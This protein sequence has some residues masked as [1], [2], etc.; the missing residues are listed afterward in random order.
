MSRS[1][2]AVAVAVGRS[3]A[4][5][6]LADGVASPALPL[7]VTI[8]EWPLPAA[9]ER[10]HDPAVGPD[11]ALWYTAQ[12][13]NRLG[14]LDPRTGQFREYP[15][16][17][18]GSGPHGLTF[19]PDGNLWYTANRA[20]LIGKLDPATG[21]VT[22]Y[23]M[24]DPRARDP[25]TPV[26]DHDGMLWFTVER[27]NMVGRLD[28]RSGKIDLREVPTQEAIPYGIAVDRRGVPFFC[29]FGTNKLASIDPHS[30]AIKEYPL[31]AGARPRRIAIAADGGVYY[32]DYSRGEL[33][34]LDPATGAVQ[35]WPSPGGPH[36]K[37]YGIATTP[38]GMVWFSESGVEPNTI[39]RFDP[40]TA[41][42]AS[43]PIPSG[44][45]VVRNIAATPDGRIYL[46]CSGVN[47]VGVV[48]PR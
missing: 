10:P 36:A 22:E 48:E 13:A 11:G 29:E 28:P 6:A 27:G 4:A 30:L 44:G 26:F 46:A 1:S 15:L 9:N 35:E 5:S 23:R 38:D 37:P 34:R 14:R 8:R 2:S 25:H 7:E 21:R 41:R 12:Q 33:G 18:P 40:R 45:G 17:T 39:V 16:P 20:G 31:P 42:F 3:M 32:T 19:G 47:Q 43:A 24:P